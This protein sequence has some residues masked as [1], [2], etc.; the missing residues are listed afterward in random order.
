MPFTYE[1]PFRRARA[2]LRLG[3]CPSYEDLKYIYEQG[4]DTHLGESERE[5]AERCRRDYGLED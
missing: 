1:L 4:L 2:S 5:L 3:V